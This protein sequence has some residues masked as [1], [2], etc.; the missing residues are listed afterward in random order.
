MPTRRPG[1]R[2]TGTGNRS[3]SSGPYRGTSTGRHATMIRS[4]GIA[5]SSSRQNEPLS[6]DETESEPLITK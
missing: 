3:A 5:G 4:G 2:G 1:I 6:I